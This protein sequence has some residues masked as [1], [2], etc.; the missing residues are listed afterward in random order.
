M[1]DRSRELMARPE[2]RKVFEEELI[3]GEA[4]D[5]VATLLDSLRISQRDSPRD[6]GCRPGESA[7]SSPGPTT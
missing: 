5:T 4:T 1:T 2:V 3:L 6:S 7:R